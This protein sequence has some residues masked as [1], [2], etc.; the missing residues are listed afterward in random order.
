MKLIEDGEMLD[1]GGTLIP[2]AALTIK[3][4]KSEDGQF[5]IATDTYQNVKSKNNKNFDKYTF[6]GKEFG[7]GRLVLSVITHHAQNNPKLTF[8]DFK[9]LFPDTIQGSHGVFATT[10]DADSTNSQGRMR[11]FTKA[12]EL[13]KLSNETIAVSNQWGTRNISKAL[14]VFK[15]LGYK[16]T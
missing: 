15:K 7:K 9:S 14:D 2:L 3:R 5:F 10:A 13:I 4:Y 1:I 11:Y 16:I 8:A 6:N 12:N